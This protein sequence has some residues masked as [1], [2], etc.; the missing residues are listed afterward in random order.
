MLKKS[1]ATAAFAVPAALIAILSILAGCGSSGLSGKVTLSGSTTVQPIAQEA[2][3]Q[4]MEDNPGA[5]VTVQG[6]GSSVGITQVSEGS[7]DIGDSSRELKDE[8]K[9][10]GLVDHKVAFDVIVLI[11]NPDVGIENLTADQ[12]TDIF[13]GAITNW[14]EVGGQDEPIEVVT[15]DSASG[16]REMFDEKALGS[17]KD[18]PVELI[19]G[20]IEANSNGIMRQNV[21]STKGAIGYI[22]YGYLD[23]SVTAL[24]YN[25]VEASLENSLDKTYPLARYLHMFTKGEATGITSEYIDFVLSPDF[26]NET[27]S[28]EY[29]PMTEVNGQ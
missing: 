5:N 23:K 4:F 17:T 2:A 15:R 28:R 22:S 20:A 24:D 25:G 1:K 16:T 18:K 19:K 3:D 11:T 10:L 26:Q 27:V 12:V 7:V 29:I 9:D 8:E 13:T 14:S 21:A 6:G